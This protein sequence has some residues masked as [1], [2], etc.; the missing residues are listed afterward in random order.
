MVANIGGKHGT[1][2]MIKYLLFDVEM[3]KNS[4]SPHFDMLSF[5]IDQS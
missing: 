2:R 5:N 1:N 3:K 4:L